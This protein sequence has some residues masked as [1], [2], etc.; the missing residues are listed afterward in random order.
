MEEEI[1]FD[2]LIMALIVSCLRESKDFRKYDFRIIF[3]AKVSDDGTIE[4]RDINIIDGN[5]K[6]TPRLFS[7]ESN[8][9]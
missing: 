1:S 9:H 2:E 3:E 7:G 4:A 8:L 5:E 6:V